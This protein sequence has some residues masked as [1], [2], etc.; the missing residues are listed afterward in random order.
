MN[1]R[2]A[3]TFKFPFLFRGMAL[4][5]LLILFPAALAAQN[6]VH[7]TGLV[8]ES[9]TPSTV[10]FNISWDKATI[11]VEQWSDS[12]WVFVDYSQN[13][14]MERLPLSSGTLVTHT[15][16]A[17]NTGLTAIVP[18]NSS[19]L[20]VVGDAKTNTA[21]S[22]TVQLL[23]AETQVTGACVYAS[24]YPPAGQYVS[25]T[26]I[27]FTGTAPYTVLLK[28]NTTAGTITQKTE[29][30]PYVFPSDY[31]VLSFSDKTG[32]PGHINCTWMAGKIDFSPPQ[33]ITIGQP[34][35][36]TVSE[37][38][39]N[40]PLSNDTYQW[41]ASGFV[42]DA[43]VGNV[44]VATAPALVGTYVVA[45]TAR[46]E[47]FCTLQTKKEVQVIDCIASD[48]YN[49]SV[50][51]TGFCA[52]ETGV[53][54]ALSGTQAGRTYYLYKDDTDVKSSLVGNGSPASF[55]V[56]NEPGL[57]TVKT[58][59]L[60][61]HCAATMDG[62]FQ[63]T[64]NPAP[65]Q[66]V[67]AKPADVCLNSGNIVFTATD[68]TGVLDWTS[69]GNGAVNGPTVTF[70]G[71]S[72]GVKAVTARAA[73]TYT[74]APT[75]YSAPTSQS[76][77]VNPLPVI[78]TQPQS[79][80]TCTESSLQLSV[81]ASGATGYQWKKNGANVTDGSGGTSANYTTAVLTASAT[82]TVEVRNDW[83]TITSAPANITIEVCCTPASATVNFTAFNACPDAAVGTTWY[84]QDTRETNNPQTYKV[85]KMAGGR[86]W[87]IQD[88]KFGDL[89]GT[90]FVGSASDQTGHVSSSGTYY[91]DCRTNTYANAGYLY[92]WAGAIN[93][94]GAYRG[95]STNV[96][97][98][99]TNGNNCQGICPAGWHIPT[100]GTSGEFYTAN[101]AFQAAYSCGN[102]ACWNLNSQWEGVFG[103]YCNNTGTFGY[104]GTRGF[105]W[106][107][108]YDDNN[109][110]SML[111]IRNTTGDFLPGTYN[112]SKRYGYSVRCIKNL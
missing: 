48:I 101:T 35:V 51:A 75:C 15:A 79:A 27:R 5:L 18:G 30:S 38:P 9:G 97:C 94:P 104:Q 98:S 42:P 29:S 41:T 14:R 72:A 16:T 58:T 66:P 32:A 95:S 4:R 63:I 20:W 70:A 57:Y 112:Y 26:S 52:G 37:N 6:G 53:T 22:A 17:A 92:D 78:S 96:G 81:T 1:T 3:G 60:P 73:Q 77:T 110:A 68:Y 10:T 24:N 62:S 69:P 65:A 46:A 111:R 25:A 109:E 84:L 50:S 54:F 40:I 28:D 13:G 64:V 83:C 105:Y 34:A 33:V 61:P 47:G 86:I 2:P 99:G 88:M 7:V 106:S 49:L 76:A 23:S 80:T 43:H 11:P 87:M 67:I 19:G 89:C 45:L 12:V 74:G 44:F 55:S 103:G 56:I 8:V 108:T 36:F 21:F 59:A 85:R 71:T 90:G 107:S 39:T 31:T 91:G 102:S 100:G 93:K 82:Y